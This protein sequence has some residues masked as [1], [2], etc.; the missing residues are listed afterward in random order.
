MT[1]EE[2]R[3]VSNTQV[4]EEFVIKV[5]WPV[6]P[7]QIV[8]IDQVGAAAPLCV[9]AK[10]QSPPPS[11]VRDRGYSMPVANPQGEES[12][13]IVPITQRCLEADCGGLITQH[14]PTQGP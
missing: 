7:S 1:L 11:K 13:I 14:G 3:P 2:I 4:V 6:I 10:T 9:C 12:G 5:V 8:N